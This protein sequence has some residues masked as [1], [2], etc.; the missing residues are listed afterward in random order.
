MLGLGGGI[1]YVPI[2]L[3]SGL[4]Y[5]QSAATA[6]SIMIV[7]SLTATIVYHLNNMVDWK[8]VFL[9]EPF[10]LTGAYIAGANSNLFPEKILLILFSAVM[11]LSAFFMIRQPSKQKQI[12]KNKPGFIQ[13]KKMNHKYHINLWL[14]IPLAFITGMISALLGVGGGFAKVPL[15]TLVFNVPTKVAVATSSAMIIVTATAGFLGHSYA[16]HVNFKLSIILSFAAFLGALVG[17]RI[18]IKSDKKFLDITF[19]IILILVSIWMLIKVIL[20]H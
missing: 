12:T 15:M 16:G 18:S 14:G 13:S 5:H 11:I 10:S 8:I 3:Q 7:L 6:L 4:T 1:L 9:L 19:G 20:Y 17:S 2:L